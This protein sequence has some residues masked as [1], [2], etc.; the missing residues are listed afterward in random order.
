[1]RTLLLLTA[2]LLTTLLL[3]A[4]GF[5]LRGQAGMPFQTLYLD[6]NAGAPMFV[7]KEKFVKKTMLTR[8]PGTTTMF[9]G[10]APANCFSTA[11]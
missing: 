6:A 4:C 11:G 9:L 3:T 8:R 10:T 1:M 2:L 7:K 5:H